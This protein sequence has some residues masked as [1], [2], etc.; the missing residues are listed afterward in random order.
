MVATKYADSHLTYSKKR[1]WQRKK[2][3]D[4][5]NIP[6]GAM[7]MQ[8]T[9][10]A[11][12]WPHEGFAAA[13]GP[14]GALP[15]ERLPNPWA[16]LEA[17]VQARLKA[18]PLTSEDKDRINEAI[19]TLKD[20]V[21][22][23]GDSWHLSLFGSVANGFGTQASDVDVTCLKAKA[24][25]PDRD[26]EDA[27]NLLGVRLGPLL[28]AHPKFKVVEEVLHAKVPILKLRFAERLDV[29]LSC[30]NQHAV[31]N[32]LLLRAYANIDRRVRELGIAVKLW[33][34][35][36]GVCGAFQ[37][38]LSS[39][40]FTLMAI[41]FMQVD[42]DICLPCLPTCCSKGD[43]Y[44]DSYR[45]DLDEAVQKVS[46]FW[47]CH[48]STAELLVRFFFFYERW[49]AWGHEVVS[50]RLG[51]RFFANSHAFEQLR[52]RWTQRLHVEDPC[53]LERNLHCVLWDCEEVRLRKAFAEA[54]A[55]LD[56]GLT[57]VGLLEQHHGDEHHARPLSKEYKPEIIGQRER[58]G[59]YTEER[60]A[61]AHGTNLLKSC[62]CDGSGL[63]HS[64]A[65]ST[66]SIGGDGGEQPLG[67]E[68]SGMGD[69]SLESS[70]SG[71]SDTESPFPASPESS[72]SVSSASGEAV[73][74]EKQ[75]SATREQQEQPCTT[76]TPVVG[77]TVHTSDGKGGCDDDGW[78]LAAGEVAIVEEVDKDGDFRLRN[79]SG[80]VSRVFQQRKIFS[81]DH[82]Q[83]T[84]YGPASKGSSEGRP[85]TSQALQWLTVQEMEGKISGTPDRH[86][87]AAAW[88]GSGPETSSPTCPTASVGRVAR[89]G[90]YRAK[91]TRVIAARVAEACLARWRESADGFH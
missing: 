58:V 44:D 74:W 84:F 52:G 8:K 76:R 40:T 3:D 45:Q 19:N 64:S 66:A 59:V 16:Y 68:C 20:T 67:T 81:Y 25:T 34:K 91:A 9:W 51:Q 62:E 35:A 36:A 22:S 77:D 72:E 17:N 32:T 88:L 30:K 6:V 61:I 14:T 75:P 13:A 55:S 53:V 80:Q 85:G 70:G 46:V 26:D 27:A 7:P 5:A 89:R 15:F 56:K 10:Q 21:G 71:N 42:P 18:C 79:P 43:E 1:S 28:R 2:L 29:D 78:R 12:Q 47:R 11:P 33:A 31:L 69:S 37:G 83:E 4:A 73:A 54:T 23:L 82:F 48:F 86:S 49:F 39:Y 90:G 41:Y 38:H 65:A 60:G 63:S 57:P 24:S 50:P 87:S